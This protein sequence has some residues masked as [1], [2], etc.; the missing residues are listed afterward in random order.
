M[1]RLFCISPNKKTVLYIIQL[2]DGIV[3]HPMRRQY[4][5]TPN[6]KTLLYIIQ[7]DD[8]IVYYPMKRQYC[9]I[10]YLEAD[11]E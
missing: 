11:T 8:S 3:Y 6:E 10:S 7:C 5:I 9:I 4:C 2:E 1:R